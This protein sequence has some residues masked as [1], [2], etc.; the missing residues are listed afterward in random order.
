MYLF[1]FSQEVINLQQQDPT[2]P[3]NVFLASKKLIEKKDVNYFK[4]LVKAHQSLNLEY[5]IFC[6]HLLYKYSV[7]DKAVFKD[8]ELTR[9]TNIASVMAALLSHLYSHYLDVPR[10]VERL[11]NE[12]AIFQ[13]LLKSTSV[14][15][16]LEKQKNTT[17]RLFCYLPSSQKIRTNT[18]IYNLPRLFLARV[19]FFLITLIPLISS[20][21][22]Y[23]KSIRFIDRFTRPVFSY[24]AWAFYAPRLVDNTL[25]LLKHIIPGPWQKETEKSLDWRTRASAHFDRRWFELGNDLAWL[26]VGLCN[27]F[28]L[29]GNLSPIA[30]YL[31]L[32]FLIF[33]VAMVCLRSYIELD[34]IRQLKTFYGEEFTQAF[35][36][37]QQ[38]A[39]KKLLL[40]VF[41]TSGILSGATLCALAMTNPFISLLG[42]SLLVAVT[43]LGFIGGKY[44]DKQKPLDKI[45]FPHNPKK[46]TPNAAKGHGFFFPAIPL[47]S[48]ENIAQ[49]SLT[50]S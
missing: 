15:S 41:N 36:K 48:S 38:F 6:T 3:K 27:C 30:V 8:K 34:R 4:E 39:I 5:S 13:T 29:I 24:L 25:V 17:C 16:A 35:A 37:H 7:A 11:D 9:Q 32:A 12:Q 33:D 20:W 46:N 44:L 21:Q 50:P 26:G 42:A 28:L 47:L 22:N 49:L 10:E 2:T 31:N 18:A 23:Q 45:S 14:L 1:S 19:R 40:N 43:L